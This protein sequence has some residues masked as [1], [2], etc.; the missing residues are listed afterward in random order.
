MKMN[1][2]M[3]IF[4][5]IAVL[6]SASSCAADSKIVWEYDAGQGVISAAVLAEGSRIA[7]LTVN[8]IQLID[9]KTGK[10]IMRVD[11]KDIGRSSHSRSDVH[12]IACASSTCWVVGG[13][14]YLGYLAK[15]NVDTGETRFIESDMFSEI[16]SVDIGSKHTIVT[17]HGTELVTVSDAE[18]MQP[19]SK[20]Q[21]SN[22]REVYAVHYD[23]KNYLVGND[24]GELVTW[25]GKS[26]TTSRRFVV[27][28]AYDESEPRAVSS[29]TTFKGFIVVGG[30]GYLDLINSKNVFDK[31]HIEFK[32]ETVMRCDASDE[33]V[34]VWCGL[35]N[36]VLVSVGLDGKIKSSE[37]IHDGSI[38][39]VK[40]LPGIV[41][42][43]SRDGTVTAQK[44]K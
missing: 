11:S 13:S 10:R 25:D 39:F 20:I 8:D 43:A 29:I 38:G 44:R 35:T 19:I 27:E 24:A 21:L 32:G 15:V 33:D 37:K 26:K 16:W 18:N 6:I 34:V 17:G 30:P 2:M 5:G 9:A 28:P 14:H 12:D 41:I 42:T 22:S 40:A 31:R 7:V 23:G 1:Y 36:G 4:F 3:K